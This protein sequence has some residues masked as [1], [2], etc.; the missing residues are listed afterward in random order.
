MKTHMSILTT[1]IFLLFI[2]NNNSAQIVDVT[3][4]LPPDEHI[5]A[6]ELLNIEIDN[7]QTKTIE[8]KLIVDLKK[9]NTGIIAE[10]SSGSFVIPSNKVVI[11]THKNDELLKLQ[12]THEDFREIITRDEKLPAGKYEIC[13][14]VINT[15]TDQVL[16]RGCIT[17]KIEEY[18]APITLFSPQ[19]GNVVHT[20]SPYFT[21]HM[22]SSD[23]SFVNIKYV[24][25]IKKKGAFFSC[26]NSFTSRRI[27]FRSKKLTKQEF[28]YKNSEKKFKD[29][30]KY[31][32][33]VD[34]YTNREK[35]G[36][37]KILSFRY[38]S[39]NE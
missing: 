4:M 25:T 8:G 6:G 37:S 7:L 27:W 17:K 9:K 33:K 32:W 5:T 39:F 28:T 15:T 19:D 38:E 18:I 1:L 13:V 31:C 30:V 10:Y 24:V 20:Q 34:A 12:R 35:I 16:F 29:G 21:W 11:S 2:V 36:T 22:K 23:K 3:I 26:K 14:R